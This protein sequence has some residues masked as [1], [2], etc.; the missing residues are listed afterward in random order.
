MKNK[1]WRI[2]GGFIQWDNNKKKYIRYAP[3]YYCK[4]PYSLDKLTKDH[5]W[6]K[7]RGGLRVIWN[8]VLS[9]VYCN[10]FKDNSLPIVIPEFPRF[11][12]LKSWINEKA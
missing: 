10:K 8:T 3:C 11:K 12:L 9:C 5:V 2:D 4:T 1:L 6:P 7:S